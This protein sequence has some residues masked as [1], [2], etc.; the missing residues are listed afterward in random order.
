MA[1]YEELEKRAKLNDNGELLFIGNITEVHHFLGISTSMYS[2]IRRILMEAGS[3]EVLQRGTGAQPSIAIL[4]GAPD[5]ELFTLEVLTA[6]RRLATLVAQLEKRCERL[7]KWRESMPLNLQEAL[8]EHETRLNELERSVSVE[9][10]N[11]ED[12]ETD[13]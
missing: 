13:Q 6:P 1:V 4:H 10:G 12:T 7:E 9:R 3:V 8:R 5:P 2:R 11:K